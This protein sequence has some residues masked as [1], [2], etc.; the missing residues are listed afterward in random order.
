MSKNAL[1]F[2]ETIGMA[3]AIEAA[4][5]ATKSANV[6]LIGYELTKG[7]GMV[8][9]KIEG[10][11][12][13]VTSA[14]NAAKISASS[15]NKVCSTLVIPRPST[16]VEKIIKNKEEVKSTKEQLK[17]ELE[18]EEEVKIEE[19]KYIDWEEVEQENNKEILKEN[20]EEELCNI[21]HDP[22]CNRKKGQPRTWCIHHNEEFEG[23][24]L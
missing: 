16:S 14:I 9:I 24:E 11:V 1:G 15:V 7:Y 4:D 23:E 8:T 5:T 22:K 12:S 21:C 2:I 3:A 19:V 10:D 18:K 13:A 17:E 20:I 6:K